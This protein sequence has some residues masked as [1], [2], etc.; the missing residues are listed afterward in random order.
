MGTILGDATVQELRESILGEVIT[1]ADPR[2]D[3]TRAVWN[4]MIDKR[5]ALIIRCAGVADVIAAVQF[6][7]SQELE[8]AVRGGGHSLPGFSTS[9]GGI[10]I[11]LSPMKGIRVDPD[12]ERVVAQGR[13]DLARARSRNAGV[14]AGAD[15]GPHL[16]DR[17]RRLHARRRDRLAHAQARPDLRQPGGGG[18]RHRGRS[19]RARQRTR[20]PGAVLGSSRRGRELRDRDL[21]RVPAPSRRADGPRRSDL[22]PGRAGDPDPARVPRV[23]RRPAGRDDDA[24]EPDDGAAGPVPAARRAR[25]EGRGGRRRVRRPARG[26]DA[27]S[28]SR[29]A[30]SGRRSPTSLGRCPTR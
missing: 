11:D 4:A 25:Q 9:D 22:L 14:R 12:A 23:H 1:P 3:E 15:R 16:D 20:E 13:R 29:S 26:R 27:G 2:Y 30:T 19:A 24:R 6:A 10:V 5:P 8:I 28:P 17:H 7:R 18:P 21:L